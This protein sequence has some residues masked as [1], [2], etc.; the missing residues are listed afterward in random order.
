MTDALA[1]GKTVHFGKHDIKN[2]EID[3]EPFQGRKRLFAADDGLTAKAGLLQVVPDKLGNVLVI[4]DDKDLSLGHGS[5]GGAGH[6]KTQPIIS[7]MP[8][9][10]HPC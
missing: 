6:F 9:I 4:L 2:D 5:P 10:S 1:H 7:Y 8:K 3:I